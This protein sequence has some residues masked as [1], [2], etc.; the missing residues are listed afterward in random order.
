MECRCYSGGEGRTRM[1]KMKFG[2][3]ESVTVLLAVVSIAAVV[4]INNL[5]GKI[6]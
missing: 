5:F 4:L 3:N 2:L 6:I 1:K